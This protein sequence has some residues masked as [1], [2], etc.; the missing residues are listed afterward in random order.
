MGI[1]AI[2]HHPSVIG[3]TDR[4]AVARRAAIAAHAQH[5]RTVLR[6]LRIISVFFSGKD[7]HR[8]GIPADP[9]TA[10]DRLCEN[11]MRCK[12][13]RMNKA[14]GIDHNIAPV[15]TNPAS[16]AKRDIDRKIARRIA[17]RSGRRSRRAGHGE[18]RTARTAAA[19]NRL[20]KDRFGHRP[21][22]KGRSDLRD[23]HRP[24]MV[25]AAAV[26]A[27]G[28]IVLIG[29]SAARHARRAGK[30]AKPA[31]AAN[32]LCHDRTT[33]QAKRRDR[34]CIGNAHRITHTAL[35]TVTAKRNAKARA[36]RPREGER[37]RLHHTPAAAADGLRQ[38]SVAIG[39]KRQDLTAIAKIDRAPRIA[40]AAR[41]AKRHRKLPR[42]GPALLGND[43]AS[44]GLPGIATAAADG[45][46]RNPVAARATGLHHGAVFDI[47]RRRDAANATLTSIGNSDICGLVFLGET[48]RHRPA[49]A[50]AAATKR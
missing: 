47:D 49:A 4:A 27:N 21:R 42:P 13:H 30:A 12:A 20:R 8:T 22:R 41:T 35:P 1:C 29:I 31:A 25:A 5:D 46:R 28:E 34:A 3:N 10:A 40:A 2:G 17:P 48:E 18:G 16:T 19:A 44:H 9:T 32:G 45:L 37:Q 38:K 36:I 43:T 23:R 33:A 24:R 11:T 14:A 39:G 6:S 50:A 7:G 26:A 15:A